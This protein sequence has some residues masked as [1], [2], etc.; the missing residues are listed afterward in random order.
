MQCWIM[1][2]T[3]A[4]IQANIKWSYSTTWPPNFTKRLAFLNCWCALFSWAPAAKGTSQTD[5]RQYHGAISRRLQRSRRARRATAETGADDVA[6]TEDR[7]G[8]QR[9]RLHYQ[10]D[11]SR[12][13]RRSYIPGALLS[14][15][16]VITT[17]YR[18]IRRSRSAATYW[19]TRRRHV[20]C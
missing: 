8:V 7:R 13:G 5:R 2:C 20:S 15:F 14:H 1:C 9:R 17:L 18:L 4:R 3:R 11:D 19:R 16:L 10:S 6:H 12:S